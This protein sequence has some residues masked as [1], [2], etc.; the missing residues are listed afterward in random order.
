MLS[1]FY[2]KVSCMQARELNKLKSLTVNYEK[3]NSYVDI[4][5]NVIVDSAVCHL[6]DLR[7]V[8]KV[9]V[10]GMTDI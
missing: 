3:L 1:A 10:H 5:Y 4:V 2:V 6:T 7:P 8:E 9:H